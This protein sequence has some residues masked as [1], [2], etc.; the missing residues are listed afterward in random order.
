MDEPPV[1][2]RDR[3][4]TVRVDIDGK[5]L[6]PAFDNRF[7]REWARERLAEARGTDVH[8]A[9]RLPEPQVQATHAT[10][11]WYGLESGSREPGPDRLRASGRRR[12]W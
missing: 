7:W 6:N 11:D 12:C 4:Q 10:L 2:Q 9:W 1:P 8:M 3:V 5:L